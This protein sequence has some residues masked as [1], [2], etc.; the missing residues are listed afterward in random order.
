MILSEFFKGRQLGKTDLIDHTWVN[1]CF[2][3]TICAH[4]RFRPPNL[5]LRYLRWGVPIR[6]PNRNLRYQ[7]NPSNLK[8]PITTIHRAHSPHFTGETYRP[9]KVNSHQKNYFS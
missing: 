3:T 6:P 7:L 1:N 9:P 8:P 4:R 2:I 5:N